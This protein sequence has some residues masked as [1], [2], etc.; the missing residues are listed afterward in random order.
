LSSIYSCTV[1][2]K[3]KLWYN[4]NSNSKILNWNFKNGGYHLIVLGDLFSKRKEKWL[5]LCKKYILIAFICFI[6]C[7]YFKSIVFKTLVFIPKQS[8][9]FHNLIVFQFLKWLFRKLSFSKQAFRFILKNYHNLV[10]FLSKRSFS[11]Q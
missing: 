8:F 2:E 9:T 4:S 3:I 10:S 6:F 5:H 7:F 1:F 11:K